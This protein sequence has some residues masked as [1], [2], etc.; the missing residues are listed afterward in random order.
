[1]GKVNVCLPSNKNDCQHVDETIVNIVYEKALSLA[2]ADNTE[3]FPIES[4]DDM[5]HTF[6]AAALDAIARE[7]AT[8]LGL[9]IEGKLKHQFTS[10]QEV[11]LWLHEQSQRT[12]NH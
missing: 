7:V 10:T 5:S 6:S 9:D 11:V 8:S 3:M 12:A 2:N 1:M 4:L